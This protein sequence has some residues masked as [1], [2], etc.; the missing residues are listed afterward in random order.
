MAPG[1]RQVKAR[2]HLVC[3]HC[4]SLVDF[5]V[6]GCGKTW[7]ETTEEGFTFQCLGCWKVD[8]LTAELARLT[9]I[10][11]GMQSGGRVIARTTNGERTTGNMTC[12]K[13]TGEKVTIEKE[14][15]TRGQEMREVDATGG[16]TNGKEM[17]GDVTKR[18]SIT[19]TMTGRKE[20]GKEN[21][22]SGRGKVSNQGDAKRRSYSEA[23][24]EGIEN[25]KRGYTEKP[26]TRGIDKDSKKTSAKNS[27]E[28]PTE[29]GYKCGPSKKY[30]KRG[31]LAVKQEEEYLKKYK[32]N[33]LINKPKQADKSDAV[34]SSS[35][36]GQEEK[37]RLSRK[38]VIWRLR[39]RGEPITLFGETEE[40]AFQRLKKL[41]MLEPEVDKGFKND[42]Q[43]AM[44]EVD[45][46]Y[47]KEVLKSAGCD[48][49][50]ARSTDVKVKDDI[51]SIEE[52]LKSAESLGKGDT[53]LDCDVILNFLKLILKKWGDALNSRDVQDK[54]AFR[55]KLT[56]AMHT[57]TV[58]YIKP[59]FRS[60]KT[61][62]VDPGILVCLVDIVRFLLDRNYLKANDAYLEMAIGN[63]PW[64]IGVTMVGIHARTGR[65]KIFARN[66]AHVLNDETQRK[67]IQALKRLMTQCQ[68]F[69]PTD[70]SRSVEY[71]PTI[72]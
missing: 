50:V 38:E 8:C 7:S 40:E 66:V 41:E 69:F 52:I 43:T 13:V 18:K 25:R 27:L 64:P 5:A 9:D 54:M 17:R 56:S 68:T 24:I 30:F 53:A 11:K 21:R 60:L 62:D 26:N 19:R 14:G 59:L 72:T 36:T 71:Q 12:R 35:Q 48:P 49:T 4:H 70:P 61:R 46:V 10:V 65:E 57:Q 34:A 63:A 55:G 39:E 42:M 3:N 45:R 23:V 47:L 28:S 37:H 51:V 2:R 44:D 16:K 67:Y 33:L 22:E 58:S 29:F 6:S 20:T 32:K 1:K 31:D 15:G